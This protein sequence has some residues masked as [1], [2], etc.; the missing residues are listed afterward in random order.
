[1]DDTIKITHILNHKEKVANT[2]LRPFRAV[3]GMPALYRSWAD[4]LGH[5]IHFHVVSAGPWQLNEPLRRFTEEAGFPRFTWD[6]RSLDIG[7]ASVLLKHI[8]ADGNDTYKFKV[9][10][11]RA[12]MTR[13]AKR[14]IV[15]VGDS[16]EKDPE[17]Y[18]KIL[19]EFPSRVDAV[20]IRNVSSQDQADRYEKLFPSKEAAEK[21]RVF[22]D[23]EEL[24]SLTWPAVA[25]GLTLLP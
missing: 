21:L 19:S 23:P 10:K 4:A 15:L 14:H 20:F 17:V 13:F 9:Q 1:M 12:F 24:P 3:P 7:D 22:L 5:N 8:N 18:A 16:G 2:F 6:M 25:Q 11:I